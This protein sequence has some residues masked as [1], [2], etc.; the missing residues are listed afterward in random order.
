MNNE[1]GKAR[2]EEGREIFEI[3]ILESP[4]KKGKCVVLSNRESRDRPYGVPTKAFSTRDRF[5]G[6]ERYLVMTCS[7][8]GA[9]HIV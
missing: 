3:L 8:F 5:L 6:G 2:R 1:S 9:C 4:A 7:Q